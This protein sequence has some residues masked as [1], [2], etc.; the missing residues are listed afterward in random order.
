MSIQELKA[1]LG[2]LNEKGKSIQAKAD[3]EKRALNPDE[4]KEIA[5]L[6]DDFETVDADLP[7][8]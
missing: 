5:Q 2:E 4:Q 3:A 1:R 7:R 6:F 8:R